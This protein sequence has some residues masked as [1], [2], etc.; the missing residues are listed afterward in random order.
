LRS[1]LQTKLRLIDSRTVDQP[2]RVEVGGAAS[3]DASVREATFIER[4]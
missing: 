2:E 3:S 1:G 4:S